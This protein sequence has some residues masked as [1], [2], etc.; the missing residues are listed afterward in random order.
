MA[1]GQVT[2]LSRPPSPRGDLSSSE[3]QPAWEGLFSGPKARPG[4]QWVHR[5]WE[6]QKTPPSQRPILSLVGLFQSL[7]Y[8]SFSACSAGGIQAE[9]WGRGG[10]ENLM[11]YLAMG[12][13]LKP[14]VKSHPP[15]PQAPLPVISIT[16]SPKQT[17][18]VS[19]GAMSRLGLS[20]FDRLLQTHPPFPGSL[21][22]LHLLLN[23]P[24]PSGTV[25]ALSPACSVPANPPPTTLP[26]S[27]QPG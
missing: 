3:S 18:C 14:A 25:P 8:S 1:P 9:D 23:P 6:E 27:L 19:A 7:K 5:G 22:T 2:P 13:S 21:S 17:P 4:S 24:L 26:S 16:A 15:R 11:V 20:G 10:R 12:L